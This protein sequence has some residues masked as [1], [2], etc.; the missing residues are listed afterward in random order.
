MRK[1]IIIILS[2]LLLIGSILI[3]KYFIDN[4]QKPKPKV[5]KIVKTVFTQTVKN[6]TTP[7]IITTNGSLVAKNKIELYTEVQGI[8]TKGSKEFKAGTRFNRGETLLK[9]NSDEFYANLQA[10]KSSLYN[11]LTAVMPD[12]RLDFPNEFIKEIFS[13]WLPQIDKERMATA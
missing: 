9:I 7:I 11:L 2:V 3:A 4:K 8:L 1:I 13:D 12:I 5:D 6:T 10:Q